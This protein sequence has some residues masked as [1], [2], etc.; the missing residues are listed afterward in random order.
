MI[1]RRTNLH[2]SKARLHDASFL[3]DTIPSQTVLILQGVA[4]EVSRLQRRR[5][6][7]MELEAPRMVGRRTCRMPMESGVECT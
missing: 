1:R 7:A 6:Q 3:L 2:A 4:Q 5:T